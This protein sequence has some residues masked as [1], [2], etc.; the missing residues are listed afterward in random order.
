M[1]LVGYTVEEHVALITLDSGENRFNPVFLDAMLSVLDD[2]QTRTAA[3]TAI[4]RSAHPKIFCNG[5]DLDWM[6]PLLQSRDTAALKLFFY[7]LNR[8]FKRLLTYPLVTIAAITGHV[9][10]GGAILTCAFDFRFMRSDRG[11]FCLPAVDLGIIMALASSFRNQPIDSGMVV[12]G[13]VGLAGEVRAINQAELRIK[14][15]AKMGFSRCLLPQN[16]INRLAIDSSLELVGVD[17]VE[18]ALDIL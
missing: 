16:N 5:I 17:S 1:G 15:A 12:F 9:F 10:A 8:L 14:E 11:Y 18:K 13:E 7:Q 6:M 3:T 2:I 4:V